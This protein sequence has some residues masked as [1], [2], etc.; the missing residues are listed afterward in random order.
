MMKPTLQDR[1]FGT[2]PYYTLTANGSKQLGFCMP[3]R[4][5]HDPIPPDNGLP[6]N[7]LTIFRNQV[8][9]AREENPPGW[10]DT[11]KLVGKHR[12]RET[13]SQLRERIKHAVQPGPVYERLLQAL[14]S[15]DSTD[16]PSF[17]ADILK[18]L[19]GLSPS[20]A[21]RALCLYFQVGLPASTIPPGPA[22]SEIDS[23]L[24][25]NSNPYDLLL[26]TENPSLL[27]LGAGD[28][29][30][31]EELIDQ[32]V[33]T[34]RARHRSLVVHAIDRLQPGSQF[35]GV[36]HASRDRLK[37]FS[38]FAGEDLRFRFWGGLDM[39]E[40]LAL[41][42]LLPRYTIV[43]CHAPATPT[44]AYEP[45]RVDPA[46]IRSHLQQTK[47]AFRT[48]RVQGE[49]ALEVHHRGKALTFPFW[50]FLI[51]GPLVLLELMARRGTLCVLSAVDTEVFWEILSQLIESE[52]VR[53]CNVIFTP[54]KIPE[55]F[56]SFYQPIS[57]LREGDRLRL[58]ELSPLRKK[59]G[60]H[61]PFPPRESSGYCF[62]SVEIRRGAVFPGIPAGF[63]ARQFLHMREE[64]PP[65]TL[66][67]TPDLPVES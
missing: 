29:S 30:F 9:K 50:K 28:L 24:L 27:D 40:S 8:K 60:F 67:L 10:E 64:T 35:G 4:P 56:G 39:S 23:L 32:Y 49:E 5:S 34:L 21:I 11:R 44:F 43:T 52:S 3:D 51:Q 18:Q 54:E 57:S 55:I 46:L 58:E 65:W 6:P 2:G 1:A 12:L 31:E 48:V 22:A 42:G 61:L 14:D 53:P 36:Y 19:T 38:T 45:R 62:R 17:Q 37:K 33:P 7:E 41:R 63:T 47:G 13:R 20:K 26:V 15:Q 25:N 16:S 59:F 66:I